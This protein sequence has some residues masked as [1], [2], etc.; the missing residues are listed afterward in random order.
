[1]TI[2]DARAAYPHLGFAVYAYDPRDDVTLEIHSAGDVFTFTAPTVSD[3]LLA[4]FPDAEPLEDP[5]A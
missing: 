3:A 2:D 1:M 4:A 5:F